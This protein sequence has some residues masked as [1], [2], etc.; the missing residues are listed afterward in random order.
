MRPPAR[1]RRSPL[2]PAVSIIIAEPMLQMAA[3]PHPANTCGWENAATI[4]VNHTAPI[5]RPMRFSRV[6]TRS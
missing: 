1:P 3:A 4:T 6:E 2:K 5:V